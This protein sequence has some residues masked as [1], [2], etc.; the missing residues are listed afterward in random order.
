MG[1]KHIRWMIRRD[2]Q[3]VLEIEN[4]SFWQPW[5]ED[6]FIRLLRQRNCIGMVLDDGEHVLGFMLYELHKNRI[7]VLR[8]AV[9]E[10]RRRS[11]LGRMFAD[12][13][14]K[15]CQ[16]RELVLRCLQTSPPMR[17]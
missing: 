9:A 5:T 12:K 6:D 3:E 1:Y 4:Q 7:E 15:S 10:G 2:M 14:R 17:G 16:K 11:G 13:L 8:F